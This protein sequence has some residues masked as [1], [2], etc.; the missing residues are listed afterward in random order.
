MKFEEFRT[1]YDKLNTHR[2]VKA[3]SKQT[4]LDEELLNVIYTQ[5]TVREATKHYHVVKRNAPRLLRDWRSGVSLLEIAEKWSFPPILTGL[6]LFQEDGYSKKE[7]WKYVREPECI[8]NPR[9]KR[10]I[11]EITEADTMDHQLDRVQGLLR[12]PDRV[13]QEHPRAAR[14]IRGAVRPWTGGLL[15]RACG[16]GRLSTGHRDHR[17]LPVQ[18]GLRTGV[19]RRLLPRRDHQRPGLRSFLMA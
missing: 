9:T 19:R 4:G 12:R 15:V 2:D 10:E 5:K 3:L 17:R 11:V 6:L 14:P 16:G 13:Q 8:A 18:H 1:L 7:F